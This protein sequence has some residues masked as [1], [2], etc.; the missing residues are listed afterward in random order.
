MSSVLRMLYVYRSHATQCYF[1]V[2]ATHATFRPS[3]LMLLS[4]LTTLE[5]VLGG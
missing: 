3:V 4:I 2:Y 1:F 5:V